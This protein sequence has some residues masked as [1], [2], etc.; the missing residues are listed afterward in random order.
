MAERPDI[1]LLGYMM[2]SVVDALSEVGTVIKA[3]G[4]ADLPAPRRAA[5]R[6]AVT[7]AVNGA[8][9]ALLDLM[10][11]LSDIVSAGAGRDL[12]DMGDLAARG[13]T[14][15]D[16][17]DLVSSDTADM[18]VALLY[19]LARDIVRADAHV[20]SGTWAGAHF[21]SRVRVSGRSVGIVGL[22]RIG[23]LVAERLEGCGLR[24]VYHGRNPRPDAPWPYEPDLEALAARVDFLVLTLPGGA[25]TERLIDARILSAL[26]PEGFLVNVARGSVVDEEA[27]I[28][29]LSTGRIAGA[30]LDVFR[31]EPAPDP[32]FAAL[33]N[34]I[35]TPHIAAITGNFA[36]ELAQDIRR[37]VDACLG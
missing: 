20:R 15:H 33:P 23:R 11:G 12:F 16:T 31:G 21:G 26:G 25:E 5:I 18:A 3:D 10:P 30:A 24:P 9:P 4:I 17:G 7:S 36:D 2:D 35:L 37:Q 6:C 22:G 14:L 28:D 29:A 34:T 13:V 27:L 1:A 8:R 32:R 19:A